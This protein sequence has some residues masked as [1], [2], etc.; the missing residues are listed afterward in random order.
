MELNWMELGFIKNKIAKKLISFRANSRI[1]QKY[2]KKLHLRPSQFGPLFRRCGR[3]DFGYIYRRKNHYLLNY[4]WE[5]SFSGRR[6]S[7][8]PISTFR[9][10]HKCRIWI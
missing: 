7:F 2:N 6:S 10:K 8:F 5:K 4:Y 9:K 3:H 1:P